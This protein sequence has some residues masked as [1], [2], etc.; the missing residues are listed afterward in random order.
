[1]NEIGRGRAAT[2]FATKNAEPLSSE[3]ARLRLDCGRFPTYACR[4]PSGS[5][6]R[7][8]AMPVPTTDD[9]AALPLTLRHLHLYLLR[10]GRSSGKAD[11]SPAAAVNCRVPL[12]VQCPVLGP[13]WS[14]QTVRPSGDRGGLVRSDRTHTAAA[15]AA[16]AGDGM[17]SVGRLRRLS[18]HIAA[19]GAAARSHR[20]AGEECRAGF[21]HS[22]SRSGADPRTT[23]LRPELPA[24]RPP[25][26]CAHRL[27]SAAWLVTSRARRSS[28]ARHAR[29]AR[30]GPRPDG[31]AL[32]PLARF[33]V[34]DR[35]ALPGLRVFARRRRRSP[36]QR[37][38][39]RQG[40][41]ADRSTSYRSR[42]A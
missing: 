19:A 24:H 8:P 5:R 26:A 9:W 3:G 23:T 25:S 18:S 29:L 31:S 33:W 38:D 40:G 34:G 6:V 2:V 10:S 28:H 36:P 16:A 4:E 39:D 35:R 41:W 11:W 17:P 15:A 14:D 32:P 21:A 22:A 12:Y 27:A 20:A 42:G 1:M 7:R 13:Q 30:P 37:P